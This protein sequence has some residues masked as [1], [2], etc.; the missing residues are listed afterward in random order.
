VLDAKLGDDGEVRIEFIGD[1]DAQAD[2]L[3]ALIGNG[4]RVTSF[5]EDSADLEDVFL[6]LTTGAVN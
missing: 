6:K 5:K 1:L 3:A 4:F 2:L